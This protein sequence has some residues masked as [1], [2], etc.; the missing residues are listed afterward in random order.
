MQIKKIR[1]TFETSADSLTVRNLPQIE[2][3]LIIFNRASGIQLWDVRATNLSINHNTIAFNQNNGIAIGGQ[4][5]ITLENN[6]IA[7][8]ERY[9]LKVSAE[10]EK[11]TIIN[12]N[13]WAN[14]V[15]GVF[16]KDNFSFDP[17]FISPRLKMDFRPDPKICCAI[18]ASDK[19]NIGTRFDF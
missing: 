14:G 12:N 9:G 13:L 6:V 16:R 18:K 11:S 7:N 17:A 2:D 1:F 10:S 19:E 8:N 5:T 15:L 4:S 3:N